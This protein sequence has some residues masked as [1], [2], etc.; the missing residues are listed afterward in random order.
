MS[1]CTELTVAVLPRS[2]SVPFVGTV[3]NGVL[4]SGTVKTGDSVLL[5]PDTL[6]H[7][8][9]TVVKSIQRKRAPVDRAEAGQSVSFALKRVR[10][11]AVRK[12]MVVLAKQEGA[13][14]PKAVRR[15]EGQVRVYL[16]LEHHKKMLTY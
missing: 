14:A 1:L 5:G 11:A 13:E 2:F 8:V 10:R 7:F 9:T 16:C 4:A 15:F 6:G 3:V 12:G